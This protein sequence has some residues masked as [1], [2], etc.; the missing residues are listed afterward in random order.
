MSCWYWGCQR[1]NF[2]RGYGA[3]W[4]WK[5]LKVLCVFTR[6]EKTFRGAILPNNNE[7]QWSSQC[8]PWNLGLFWNGNVFIVTGNGNITS[9]LPQDESH[10]F[11]LILQRLGTSVWW[12]PNTGCG[13]G[14]EQ[15]IEQM[16]RYRSVCASIAVCQDDMDPEECLNITQKLS[17][18]NIHPLR[19]P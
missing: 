11:T 9:G 13:Y 14:T 6:G 7:R 3:G 16:K 4:I 12:N 19:W 10:F 5:M 1:V 2:K 8:N 17:F 15:N 18:L